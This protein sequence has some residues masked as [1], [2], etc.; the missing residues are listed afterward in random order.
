M[1]LQPSIVFW[2]VLVAILQLVKESVAVRMMAGV[3]FQTA[4]NVLQGQEARI[5]ILHCSF[6]G[7]FDLFGVMQ[8]VW[9]VCERMEG[10]FNLFK[11][12]LL[13]CITF[14]LVLLEL[15]VLVLVILLLVFHVLQ[16]F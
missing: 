7:R 14:L 15:L 13:V 8:I 10:T 2:V 1:G 12:L 6:V 5:A 4:Q 9:L 11:L 16:K 3:R